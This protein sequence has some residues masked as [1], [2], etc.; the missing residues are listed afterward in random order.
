[1][2][3]LTCKDCSYAINRFVANEKESFLAFHFQFQFRQN[4]WIDFGFLKSLLGTK[5]MSAF[6]IWCESEMKTFNFL[7]HFYGLCVLDRFIH[8]HDFQEFTSGDD[9][10]CWWILI[11]YWDLPVSSSYRYY[12][13]WRVNIE[14]F[15]FWLIYDVHT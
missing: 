14:S 12:E 6:D 5:Y 15:S 13:F 11:V 7:H 2:S 8:F 1:M 4:S 9:R 3:C 10:L